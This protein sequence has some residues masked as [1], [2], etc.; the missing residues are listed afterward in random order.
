MDGRRVSINGMATKTACHDEYLPAGVMV[1]RS[2]I[3]LA[4]QC[5]SHK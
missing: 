4:N 5:L 1:R 3:R 2:S